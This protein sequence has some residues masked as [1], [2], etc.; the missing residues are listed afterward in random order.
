MVAASNVKGFDGQTA[1]TTL[2]AAAALTLAC[3]RYTDR[4]LTSAIRAMSSTMRPLASNLTT[5]RALRLLLCGVPIVST[6]LICLP[7][8]L[9][10]R[11]LLT[12]FRLAPPLV[13]ITHL[14][15]PQF[16]Q[17]HNRL[18][19]SSRLTMAVIGVPVSSSIS[20]PA[21]STWT[22]MRATV[23]L[24]RTVPPSRSLYSFHSSRAMSK[25]SSTALDMMPLILV[26]DDSPV[27]NTP[28]I[29]GS[30]FGSAPTPCLTLCLK[31]S[32]AYW[33]DVMF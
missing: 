25:S 30:G 19:T 33:F 16:G 21:S 28:P 29:S 5:M 6:V 12:E 7:Q 27:H 4:S 15:L 23:A 1:A 20:F 9:Q 11:Y 13:K 18:T 24:T 26:L 17:N 32:G 3:A 10:S 22:R 14:L 31:N 8:F 2:A